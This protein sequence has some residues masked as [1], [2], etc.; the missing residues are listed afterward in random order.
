[1]ISASDFAAILVGLDMAEHVHHPG[2]MTE[3]VRP[4]GAVNA[5]VDNAHTVEVLLSALANQDTEGAGAVLDDNL[6]YQNVG[7]PTVRGRARALKLFDQV[8][9]GLGTRLRIRTAS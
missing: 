8:G 3:I 4:N 5:G 1:M 2:R 6:V 7:F 9:D